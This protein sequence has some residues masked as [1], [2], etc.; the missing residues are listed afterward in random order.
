M[1]LSGKVALVTGGGRGIGAAIARDL[2]REGAAVAVAA[3]TVAQIEAVAAEITA[4][5]GRAVA[6]PADV[7]DP[8]Q[9]RRMVER[10]QDALGPL[11]VLVNNAGGESG[12]NGTPLAEMALEQWEAQLR[13]NL[14]SALL[15][16]QAALPGMAARAEGVIINIASVVGLDEAYF[17]GA[18]IGMGAY[19]AAKAGL[20]GLSRALADELAGKGIRVHAVCPGYVE[21]ELVREE[22]DRLADD[23]GITPDVM[24]ARL[25]RFCKWGRMLQPD[26]VA[27][28]I[29]FLASDAARA[30]TRQ[31]I[32]IP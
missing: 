31:V 17:R 14:T 23:R 2:A 26:E 19:V 1:R 29:A 13:L 28:L 5:G 3:R 25:G 9:V 7:C 12:L 21:T 30:M 8:A 22:V 32:T 16:T 11:D 4:A 6:V 18:Y 24:R 10:A 27:P 20:V 15:C